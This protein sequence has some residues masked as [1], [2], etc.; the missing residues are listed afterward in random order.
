MV[1]NKTPVYDFIA[2]LI[3]SI[4]LI[5]I[6]I[7]TGAFMAGTHAGQSFNTYPLMNGKIIPDDYYMKDLG[8]LN[9]F[10]NSVAINF[11]HR[12]IATIAF[13]NIL[14]FSIYSIFSKEKFIPNYYLYL[15]IILV[16]LQFILG[17]VT[18]LTNVNINFASMH[19]TNSVLLLSSLIVAYH[20][21]KIKNKQYW[22]K[23]VTN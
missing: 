14:V 5:L 10:E 11:N 2:K 4:I 15:I 9:I 13:I 19:Q 3:L 23:N 21:Y 16:I 18:L 7:I 22:L 8:I 17:I 20:K 12:W 6:T 1:P